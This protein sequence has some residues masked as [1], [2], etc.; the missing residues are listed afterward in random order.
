MVPEDLSV[1]ICAFYSLVE[2]V[3][4]LARR[5]VV[6]GL[7]RMRR[8]IEQQGMVIEAG[9]TVQEVAMKLTR[10]AQALDLELRQF[11]GVRFLLY[12]GMKWLRKSVQAPYVANPHLVQVDLT[13]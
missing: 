2:V 1:M 10:A 13:L 6:H 12:T 4:R 7:L 5:V 11:Q 9:V 3:R 8:H